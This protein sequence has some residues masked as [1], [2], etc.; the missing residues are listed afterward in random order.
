[1]AEKSNLYISYQSIE[2]ILSLCDG[3]I[4]SNEVLANELKKYVSKIY[5][6][7]IVANEEMFKLSKYSMNKNFNN[8][9]TNKILISYFSENRVHNSDINF[10][11]PTLKK[12][13]KYYKNVKLLFVGEIDVPKSLEEFDKQIGKIKLTNWKK[14]PEVFSKININIVPIDKTIINSAISEK[15]WLDAALVKVPTVASN[16]G[17]YSNA[18]IHGETGYLC[19]TT[20]DWDNILNILINNISLQN[21]IGENAYKVCIEKYNALRTGINLS[22]YLNSI[23]NKHIGFISPSSV[24]SGGVKVILTHASFLQDEGWDVDIIIPETKKHFIEF[25]GHKFNVIGIKNAFISSQYDVLVATLYSTLYYVMQYLKVKKKLYLVQWYET[26]FSDYGTNLRKDGE[27]T[28]TLPYG[29]E[30]IT[31]SKWCQRWLKEK[32]NHDAKFAPNG[33]DL[34]LFKEHKRNLSNSKIRILIEGDNTSNNKNVDESFK[35]VEKLDKD[36]F[37]IW[38]M[39]SNGKPKKWYKY[40]KFFFEVPYEKVGQIYEQCDILLKSSILES[41][42]Y[43]PLEM[44]ATGGYCIVAPNEGNKEYLRDKENCLLYKVGDLESAVKCIYMLIS[45]KKLQDHLY[46]T[47]LVTAK[48]RKLENIREQILSLYQS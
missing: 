9:K 46:E 43:P 6:N 45:D 13:L 35:I 25:M 39:S 24:I 16:Y 27:K 28:Y 47:G 12:I 34:N 23:T 29:V 10:I 42:S 5:V 32:Y 7:K 4:T 22:Y 37:E 31:I 17:A 38:F 26:D 30:Y 1:M 19:N 15:L 3:A 48:E 20:E 36:K 18:I 33:I 8:K 21:M 11:I 44:M 41:F 2:K 14:I 40:D